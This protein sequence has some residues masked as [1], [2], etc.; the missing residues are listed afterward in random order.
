MSPTARRSLV[1]RAD[2]RLSIVALPRLLK[3]ARSDSPAGLECDAV[4]DYNG[5]TCRFAL[6]PP[7]GLERNPVPNSPE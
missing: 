5:A 3:V 6:E 1:D 7:A 2:P 4:P